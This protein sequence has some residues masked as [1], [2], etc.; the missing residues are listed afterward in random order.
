MQIEVGAFDIMDMGYIDN[1]RLNQ[2]RESGDFFIIG[3]IEYMAFE[4]VNS[5]TV[6]IELGI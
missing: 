1:H 3:A 6:Y 2:I 5:Q 4:R